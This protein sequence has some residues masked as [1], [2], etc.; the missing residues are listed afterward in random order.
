MTRKVKELILEDGDKISIKLDSDSGEFSAYYEGEWYKDKDLKIVEKGIK[1]YY[2]NNKSLQ[3]NPV[4]VILKPYGGAVDDVLGFELERV[5]RAKRLDGS[6][7]Y[8]S[9]NVMGGNISEGGEGW[10]DCVNH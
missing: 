1:D 3:Y 5:F 6:F 9:W 2:K 8:K 4:I 7:A 10:D